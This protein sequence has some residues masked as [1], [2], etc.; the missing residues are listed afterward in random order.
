VKARDHLED[1]GADGRMILKWMLRNEDGRVRTGFIWLRMGKV[2]QGT[3]HSGC[4]KGGKFL[5]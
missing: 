2:E 3:E 1:A 5:D 4:I